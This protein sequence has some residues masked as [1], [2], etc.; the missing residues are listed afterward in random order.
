MNEHNPSAHTQSAE[1]FDFGEIQ[2]ISVVDLD[3][4]HA[5][6]LVRTLKLIRNASAST[7]EA[8]VDIYNT[9]TEEFYSIPVPKGVN[10]YDVMNTPNRYRNS[11]TSQEAA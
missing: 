7:E 5:G 6:G 8:F 4:I 10:P 9:K 11:H 3:S 1:L 2:D